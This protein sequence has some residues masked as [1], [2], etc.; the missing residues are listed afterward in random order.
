MQHLPVHGTNSYSVEGS[1]PKK[2]NRWRKIQSGNTSCRCRDIQVTAVT[3]TKCNLFY[4]LLLATES[5]KFLFHTKRSQKW[6]RG[7]LFCWNPPP[8]IPA[9]ISLAI[10]LSHLVLSLQED[11]FQN[12]SWFGYLGLEPAYEETLTSPLRIP[13]NSREKKT[14]PSSTPQHNWMQLYKDSRNE[15]QNKLFNRHFRK[16]EI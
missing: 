11:G 10:A 4:H 16:K 14:V 3:V 6:G 7:H 15:K 1:V 8:H 5:C 12:G 13:R 9:P 2:E